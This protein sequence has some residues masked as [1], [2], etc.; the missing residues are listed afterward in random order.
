[1]EAIGL[2]LDVSRHR[3]FAT[4]SP[5]IYTRNPTVRKEAVLMAQEI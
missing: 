5:A 4:I 3:S 2:A 1:M